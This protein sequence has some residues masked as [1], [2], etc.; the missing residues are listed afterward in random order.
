MKAKEVINGLKTAIPTEIAWSQGEAYGP[1]NVDP[2]AD[3][4]KILYCVTATSQVVNFFKKNGYDLLVSHHPYRVPSIPQFIAHTALDCCKGGLNDQWR[5][6][7]DIKDPKNFDGTLGWYGKID[8]ISF[9]DLIKKCEKFINHRVIGQT[10]SELKTIES[11]VVCSGLGGLV[12]DLARAT[13]AQCYILGEAMSP[14]EEMG[15]PAV[16][17]I[18]HTLSEQMGVSLIQ[19]LFPQLQVDLAPLEIDTFSNEVYR[20]R[21]KR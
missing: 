8:P 17:E 12:T 21:E 5:E 4:K 1:S 14:A 7:L 11:V 20:R 13:K 10:Y 18:G 3:I 19:K 9:P 16:I 6:A 15:I 2:E